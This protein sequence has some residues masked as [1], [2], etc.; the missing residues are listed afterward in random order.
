[1]GFTKTIKPMQ[2]TENLLSHGGKVT[3]GNMPSRATYWNK[4]LEAGDF[5]L[6]FVLQ[7]EHLL[8][9]YRDQRIKSWLIRL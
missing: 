6:A 7:R 8:S 9:G 3:L 4:I 1:V 5:L 2:R